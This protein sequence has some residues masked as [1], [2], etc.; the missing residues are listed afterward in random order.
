[1]DRVEQIEVEVTFVKHKAIV[2]EDQTLSLNMKQRNN[3]I[4]KSRKLDLDIGVIKY[5]LLPKKNSIVKQENIL[6]HLI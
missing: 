1:V 6:Y 2:K 5:S 3:S 4:N